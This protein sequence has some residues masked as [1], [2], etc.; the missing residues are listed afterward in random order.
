[1]TALFDEYR[2]GLKRWIHSRSAG[3]YKLIVTP[4]HIFIDMWAGDSEERSQ[5]FVL[6]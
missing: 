1:L 5:R 3:S 2:P 6:R 4:R